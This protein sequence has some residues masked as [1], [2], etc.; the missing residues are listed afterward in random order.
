MNDDVR[1]SRIQKLSST[2]ANQIAAGEVVERPA[3]VIKELLENAIDANATRISIDVQR[4]GIASIKVTDNGIGIHP[5]DL[6]LALESHATSKIRQTTDL[7]SINSLG[8]R[9]EALASIA[10]VAHFRID[11]CHDSGK[12]G[13]SL[14][15]LPGQPGNIEPVAHNQGTTVE[16]RDLFFNTP[17]RRKFLRSENTEYLHIVSLVKA[18]ALSQFE[19]AF[20]LKHNGRSS[21]SLSSSARDYSRRV[22]DICGQ[23]FLENSIPFD[24][25]HDDMRLWGWL[26]QPEI[27]RSQSDRQYLF[28]NGRFIKD[29]QINH[30]VRL[31]F[32]DRL[33]HGRFPCYVLFLEIDPLLVDVNVHPTKQE[34]RF[35]R[36]RDVHDFVYSRLQE[37]LSDDFI[38]KKSSAV[39]STAGNNSH[40]KDWQV[41]EEQKEYKS[42]YKTDRENTS[43]DVLNIGRRFCFL[44]IEQGILVFDSEAVREDMVRSSLTM[45]LEKARVISRPLLMPVDFQAEDRQ[46]D[47]L[48]KQEN[49]L[50]VTGIRL[51]RVAPDRLLVKELPEVCHYLDIDSFFTEVIE[52]CN[53]NNIEPMMQNEIIEILA[54]HANDSLPEQPDKNDQQTLIDY[55]LHQQI[56]SNQSNNKHKWRIL[57]EQDLGK[58]LVK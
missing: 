42:G 49:L 40:S 10:S 17:A 27:A 44:E 33:Y 46:L 19:C 53:K 6:L 43:H 56:S 29:K 8:F 13:A 26:G 15:C 30:A 54:K 58:I 41:E 55:C 7:E 57:D 18:T 45:Q 32:Q 16:I 34:V 20:K 36:N 23:S 31:A 38:N 14:K 21:L 51:K 12:R 3:S 47:W 48:E 24:F 39:F 52:L 28:L 11:S 4:A 50:A 37:V 5:D 2:L 9:G 22:A 25:S 1:L 35:R